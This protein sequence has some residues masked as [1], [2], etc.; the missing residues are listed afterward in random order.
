MPDSIVTVSTQSLY[1]PRETVMVWSPGGSFNAAGVTPI[2]TPS[3]V[4]LAIFG[5]ELMF[6][7]PVLA[8]LGVEGF[9]ADGCGL[10][11]TVG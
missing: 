7:V 9:A 1:P 8:G 10:G 2:A 5:L 4:T 6:S 3:T 11:C